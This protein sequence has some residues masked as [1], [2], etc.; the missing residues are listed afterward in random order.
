MSRRILAAVFLVSSLCVMTL[1]VWR[2]VPSAR[3]TFR[4]LV[5]RPERASPSPHN[6]NTSST[7]D[8][9][10]GARIVAALVEFETREADIRID[11]THNADTVLAIRA[12]APRGIPPET[13]V[14]KIGSIAQGTPYRVVDAFQKN[15]DA[16]CRIVLARQ[17]SSD[18]IVV[19]LARSTQFYS[20]TARMAIVVENF[21][22]S[23]DQTTVEFLRFPEPLTVTLTPDKKASSW[24][25]QIANEYR[26][27]IIVAL[28]MEP[29]DT[30][31]G[32]DP[33]AVVMVHYT[34][35][36]IRAIVDEAVRT[37]PNFSGF[38][39]FKGTRATGDSRVVNTVLGVVRR[40][41]GYF[42]EIA[43]TSRSVVRSVARSQDLPYAVVTERIDSRAT[44]AQV[45]TALQ[46][47]AAVAQ[48]RGRI[49][50]SIPPTAAAIAGLT[51]QLP[52][53]KRNGIKM[54]YV[55]EVVGR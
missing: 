31:G 29:C 24:A 21:R 32:I 19:V 41:H 35:D 53:L 40:S 9:P 11:S 2:L 54:T 15:A 44:G 22:F 28:A 6:K 49:V 43:P 23:A 45:E 17:S 46:R 37:V 42:M 34:D 8:L 14:W 33:A 47:L 10:I 36:A 27:E 39:N 18:R 30:A 7:R 25:S 1:I 48:T 3:V 51:A 50:V 5:H 38:A 52:A 26:K 55:S 16:P 12:K 13:L 4:E 20:A